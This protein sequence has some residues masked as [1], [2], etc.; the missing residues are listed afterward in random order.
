MRS[1]RTRIPTPLRRFVAW[2]LPLPS[3]LLSPNVFDVRRHDIRDGIYLVVYWL[4]EPFGPGPAASMLVFGDEVIR[5]DCLGPRGHMHLNMKQSRGF[6]NGGASRLYYR[7]RTIEE[8]IQRSCFELENNVRYALSLNAARRIR[9]IRLEGR[10]VAPAV[11]FLRA[12]MLDLLAQH[13][14]DSPLTSAG[15]PPVDQAPSQALDSS[16]KIKTAR[17]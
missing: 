11:I 3:R 10:E 9:G 13:R 5:F 6:P 4:R 16:N 8:Q 15:P 2:L 1:L 12:Q 7:E 17:P 14:P